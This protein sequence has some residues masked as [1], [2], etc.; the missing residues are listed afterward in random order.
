MDTSSKQLGTRTAL[1]S[2]NTL[3]VKPRALIDPPLHA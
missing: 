1:T 3:N 2:L